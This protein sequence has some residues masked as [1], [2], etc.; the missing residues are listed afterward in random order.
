M[1][2]NEEIKWIYS[3]QASEAIINIC[4]YLIIACV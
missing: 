3:V 2:S 1:Y 4:M